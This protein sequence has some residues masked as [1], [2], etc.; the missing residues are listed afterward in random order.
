VR[1]LRG[2]LWIV[3]LSVGLAAPSPVIVDTD[4]GTDDLMAIA[5]LLARKDVRIE[6]ITIADGLAHVQAGGANILR[7]LQAAGA[8]GIPV[9]LGRSEP[10]ERTAPFPAEWRQT[11]DTLP[12]VTLPASARP[13][14]RVPAT[15]F[16][17]ARLAGSRRPIRLL[18]LGPR[19]HPGGPVR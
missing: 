3:P 11:S 7:M 10:L 2:C 4:A 14:E 13:P 15:D 9:Y 12:G 17:T 5:F 16:L 18:A 1:I 19:T 6:A 8:S